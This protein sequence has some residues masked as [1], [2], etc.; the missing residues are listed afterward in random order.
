METTDKIRTLTQNQ[1]PTLLQEITD[2]PEKLFVRGSLPD[3]KQYTFLCVVGS[4]KYS[5]YGKEICEKL[6]GDLTGY[7]IVIVSGL[8]LGIDSIAHKA[9]LDARLPT[10]AVPGSGL[11]WK[12]LYPQTH[13]NL[14]RRILEAGGTL[15]SEFEENFKA[16]PWS[17]PKRN[18]IMAGLSH[19]TL[20]IEAEK[21]SG[22]LI[23][24]RL[25]MEYNRDVLAVPGSIF[26]PTTRGTLALIKD[27][28][29]P[30][31]S[32]E[33]ILDALDIKSEVRVSKLETKNLSENEKRVLELLHEP[34][35]K[36]ELI[37][38]LDMPT[39][40]AHV[41]LSAMEIK[42]LIIER[43]GAMHRMDD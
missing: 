40:K 43:M 2:A 1:F 7:P 8:A 19:A 42:K 10:I 3:E 5:Q 24:A 12:V 22:T 6:I 38:K 36:D 16:A 32:S 11:G 26:S 14:A 17:F 27:G 9:A 33:D 37:R 20:V 21:K 29:A 35:R 28:A 41:L 4:R 30:I 18:R 13:V 39:H 15:V 34:L 25:A 23:T 31:T